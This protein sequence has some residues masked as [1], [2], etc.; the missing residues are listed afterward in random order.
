MS[1][2]S[3]NDDIL[4]LVRQRNQ[5]QTNSLT[6]RNE[7]KVRLLVFRL[8]NEWYAFE[9]GQVREISRLTDVTR[10][11]LTPAHVTGVVNLR[12]D[13]TAVID[14]RAT[15]GLAQAALDGNAR[16]IVAC[17]EQLEAGIIA[18]AVVE[19]IE[20][21]RS[22]LQPPLLAIDAERGRFAASVLEQKDNRV[23]IVLNLPI[24]LESLKV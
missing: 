3:P 19:M 7:P 14:I 22:A 10:V 16:I 18:E 13:I 8:A 2:T 4:N 15:L 6:A 17:H 9:A 23:I 1:D 5:N 21:P 24:L 20:T 12:G 11:P